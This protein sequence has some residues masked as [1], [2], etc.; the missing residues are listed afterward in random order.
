MNNLIK[1]F[2]LRN[3]CGNV[4]ESKISRKTQDFSGIDVNSDEYK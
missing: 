4:N 1:D 3:N 2:K